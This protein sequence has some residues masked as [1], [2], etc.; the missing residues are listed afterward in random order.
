[1]P[2]MTGKE[3]KRAAALAYTNSGSVPNITTS[4]IHERDRKI[5]TPSIVRFT[6]E[7]SAFSSQKSGSD[8][9]AIRQRTISTP[10]GVSNSRTSTRPD[11]RELP[12]RYQPERPTFRP[13]SHTPSVVS[14]ASPMLSASTPGRSSPFISRASPVPSRSMS[15]SPNPRLPVVH[16]P[17]HQ[18]V[19][20]GPPAPKLPSTPVLSRTS[21]AE[22]RPTPERPTP[23]NYQASS[24]PSPVSYLRVSAQKDPTPS[25]SRLQGRGFVQSMVKV[26]SQL[27]ASA[28]SGSGLFRDKIQE[29]GRKA[30][31]LDR[32]QFEAG[33]SAGASPTSPPIIS[34][35]PIT[36]RKSRT[37]DPSTPTH[38]GHPSPSPGSVH[39][40]K[41]LKPDYTGRSLKS[42]LPCPRSH[43]PRHHKRVAAA[44]LVLRRVRGEVPHL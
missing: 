37:I 41:P 24:Q 38:S 4:D 1:M 3:E 35:K 33:K 39:S 44:P 43:S 9:T 42:V 23:D 14:S 25:I 22:P 26:S 40:T 21:K 27:E 12:D 16:T 8:Q 20:T 19:G 2:G 28:Y 30:N 13:T 5:S 7:E 29:A 34:P 36:M 31:V 18:S 10:T 17:P 15:T 32:W 11:S 6:E